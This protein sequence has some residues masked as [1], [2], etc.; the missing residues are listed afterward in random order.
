MST[1]TPTDSTVPD[2]QAGPVPDDEIE[3]WLEQPYH[4][5]GEVRQFNAVI[6]HTESDRRIRRMLVYDQVNQRV[7]E[8]EVGL[9]DGDE[10]WRHD[11][12]T[13]SYLSNGLVYHPGLSEAMRAGEYVEMVGHDEP[14]HRLGPGFLTSHRDAHDVELR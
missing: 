12:E 2:H 7:I 11:F 10:I 5:D 6:D 14:G 13:V 8:T 4:I 1:E 9:I 3:M